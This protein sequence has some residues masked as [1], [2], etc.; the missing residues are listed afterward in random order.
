MA[1]PANLRVRNILPCKVLWSKTAFSLV[2]IYA[3]LRGIDAEKPSVERMSLRVWFRGLGLKFGD[4]CTFGGAHG[5]RRPGCE[6]HA[7]GRTSGDLAGESASHLC[8]HEDNEDS[9][10]L[11]WKPNVEQRPL[12]LQLAS[13]A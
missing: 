2:R 6:V 7:Q 12:N 11:E 8:L 9:A 4:T 5:T 10:D 13:R 3:L 1:R